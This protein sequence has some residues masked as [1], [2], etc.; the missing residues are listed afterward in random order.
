MDSSLSSL[1]PQRNLEDDNTNEQNCLPFPDIEHLSET[2]TTIV[3][4]ALEYDGLE[5]GHD[6]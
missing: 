2:L 4:E 1:T 6:H 5:T 3:V